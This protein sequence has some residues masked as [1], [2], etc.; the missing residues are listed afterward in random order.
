MTDRSNSASAD[1]DAPNDNN[2]KPLTRGQSIGRFI[3]RAGKLIPDPVIIFM[4]FY[5]LAFALT[6]VF[7]GYG[8]STIGAGGEAVP[9][10]TPDVQTGIGGWAR[11]DVVYFLHT[12]ATPDGDYT[13]GEMA[14]VIDGGLS[15]LD[16]SDLEAM[17]DYLSSISPVMHHIERLEKSSDNETR[18]KDPWD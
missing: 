11:D 17:A 3:E 10:I 1:E 9:N 18:E 15:R 5:P 12:G 6:V 8:F 16:R 7:G 4:A 14:E 2:V 13:G